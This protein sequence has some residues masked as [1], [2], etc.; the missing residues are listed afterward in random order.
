M[1]V[2]A[3]SGGEC[4]FQLRI[5]QN[6]FLAGLCPDPLDELTVQVPRGSFERARDREGTKMKGGKG[7]AGRNG[8][9][10]M[11]KRNGRRGGIGTRI[12]T[13]TSST[14]PALDRLIRT[15]YTSEWPKV[16]WR[17]DYSKLYSA[18]K[19]SKRSLKVR[20]RFPSSH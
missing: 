4:D 10:R 2:N 13:G 1:H 15:L 16:L 9:G 17:F 19:R 8:G 5:H 12:H 18:Q 6:R 7:K 11:G 14:L 20:M 3:I